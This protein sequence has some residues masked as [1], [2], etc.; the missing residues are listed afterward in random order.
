MA[1]KL[2]NRLCLRTVGPLCQ[3]YCVLWTV[4]LRV[5]STQRVEHTVSS[6]RPAPNHLYYTS[7]YPYQVNLD[8]RPISAIG[9]DDLPLTSIALKH[10]ATTATPV[11][12]STAKS[13]A[14]K[15]HH[16]RHTG[17]KHQQLPAR[18]SGQ[19]SL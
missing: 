15:L 8:R 11:E 3:K 10:S 2:K 13:S 18:Q 16:G 14:T 17:G 6:H 5:R 12:W 9:R 1:S 19:A 7:G 4:A